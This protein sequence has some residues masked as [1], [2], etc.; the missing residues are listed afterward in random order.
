MH[1]DRSWLRLRSRVGRL[2]DAYSNTAFCRRHRFRW[3][4]TSLPARSPT[5][6][7]TASW[8]EP[9]SPRRSFVKSPM[10]YS[11]HLSYTCHSRLRR[12]PFPFPGEGACST[13]RS[14]RILNIV[15]VI[16]PIGVQETNSLRR[17]LLY[18]PGKR[19]RHANI[20]HSVTRLYGGWYILWI[21]S[22]VFV[23]YLW[24]RP[25][26]S[27]SSGRTQPSKSLIWIVNNNSEEIKQQSTNKKYV[28]KQTL[29]IRIYKYIYVHSP[30]N[31]K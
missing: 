13:E 23:K 5:I 4:A 24:I 20:P 2:I 26:S 25:L 3:R 28:E 6:L 30:S 29:F 21:R 16:L 31:Y 17:N 14:K 22:Q 8:N 7:A 1:F 11:G 9:R 15:F 12:D 18:Y 27:S 10:S 19:S